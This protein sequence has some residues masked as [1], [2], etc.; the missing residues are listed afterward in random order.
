[1]EEVVIELLKKAGLSISTAESCTGGLVSSRLINV[2]G[3]SEVFKEG[4]IAYSNESK[5][6]L[7]GVA[8]ETLRTFGAVSPRTAIEMARGIAAV[9]GSNI[10][11]ATTGIAGPGGGTKEKPIGLVYV[12]LWLNGEEKAE[13]LRLHG[14]RNWIRLRTTLHA[15]NI[16]RKALISQSK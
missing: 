9:S 13:E 7:L 6:N 4:V 11:L 8:S 15:L 2:P 5:K 12:G 16:L 10:G 14:D 3:A 1:M